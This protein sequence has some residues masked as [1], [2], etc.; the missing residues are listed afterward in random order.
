MGF[1]AIIYLL[2]GMLIAITHLGKGKVGEKGPLTTFFSVT[3]LWPLVL[4]I[5]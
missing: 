4:W 2:I 1:F 3:L 5:E